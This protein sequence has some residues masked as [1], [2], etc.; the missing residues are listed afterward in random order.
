MIFG[1]TG[2]KID[3]TK[4]ETHPLDGTPPSLHKVKCNESAAVKRRVSSL[5]DVP[6]SGDFAVMC[7]LDM[8]SGLVSHGGWWNFFKLN[9][10]DIPK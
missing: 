5:L 4:R 3:P 8:Y 7:L 9:A 1:I 2:I 6:A 10:Q